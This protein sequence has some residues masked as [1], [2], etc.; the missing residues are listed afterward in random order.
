MRRP[1][2]GAWQEV[3]STIVVALGFMLSL[4]SAMCFG[5]YVLPR[6]Y[7]DVDPWAYSAGMGVAVLGLGILLWI[8][9]A[10]A[11]HASLV[12]GG[13]WRSAFAGLI[14]FLSNVAYIIAIDRTGVA[15]ANAFKNL[16]ALFATVFGLWLTGERLLP[17]QTAAAVAGSLLIVAAAL[18]IGGAPRGTGMPERASGRSGLDPGGVLMG[19]VAAAG[20][21]YYLVPALPVVRA[22]AWGWVQFQA[23]LGIFGGLLSCAP[24]V[25]RRLAGRG[26]RL[27]LPSLPLPALAGAL[28]FAGSSL[29]TPATLLVGLAI[30]WPLSQLS[31]YVTLLWGI[32]VFR[33]IDL[34][35]AQR[36]VWMGSVLTLI[37]L[38]LFGVARA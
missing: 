28:W 9:L 37:A 5:A 25:L 12:A 22:S 33:E 2:A 8:G 36:A 38:V 30:S 10:L 21:G 15:R 6:R 4:A 27:A 1:C 32:S 29:V 13:L 17:W 31:F 14:W 35:R 20:I 23:L 19:L 7:S 11:G 26:Q 3:G 34:A 16:T 18:T 24:Y